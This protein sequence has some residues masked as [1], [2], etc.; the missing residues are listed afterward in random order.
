M[1]AAYDVPE[2]YAI[3]A[4]RALYGPVMNCEGYCITL[5]EGNDLRPRLHA[6]ALFREYEF[7]ADEIA[8]RLGEQN[9]YLNGKHMLPIEV[10]ME[11]VVVAGAI[12]EEQRS[13]PQL[14]RIVASLQEVHVLLWIADLNPHRFIPSV[15]YWS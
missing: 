1:Q 2:I 14:A 6:R 7:T 3:G 8:L 5:A 4:A 15:R 11:A 12:L 13:W 9:R 10:L